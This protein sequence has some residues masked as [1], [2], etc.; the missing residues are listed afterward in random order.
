MSTGQTDKITNLITKQIKDSVPDEEAAR[1]NRRNKVGYVLINT[2]PNKTTSRS[3]INKVNRTQEK[4]MGEK[5]KVNFKK[6]K[7]NLNDLF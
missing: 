1:K 4:F 2:S 7:Y 6:L 5:N 3:V